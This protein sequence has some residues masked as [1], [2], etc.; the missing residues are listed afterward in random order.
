MSTSTTHFE[1]R[2]LH[3]R[4]EE[5]T[6]SKGVNLTINLGENHALMGPTAPAR[7]RWPM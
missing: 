1:I 6:S 5:K 3:A 7:A 2:N 4:C